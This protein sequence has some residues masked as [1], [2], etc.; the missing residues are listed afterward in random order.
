MKSLNLE[1]IERLPL[2]R[3]STDFTRT[4]T[5]ASL[6]DVSLNSSQVL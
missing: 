5:W 3:L 1:K 4:I 6:A 2:S